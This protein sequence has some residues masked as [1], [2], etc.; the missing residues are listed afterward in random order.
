MKAK[1]LSPVMST[2]LSFPAHQSTVHT[3]PIQ[4]PASRSDGADAVPVFTCTGRALGDKW[5][6]AARRGGVHHGAALSAAASAGRRAYQ[7]T[8]A[9]PATAASRQSRCKGQ[10]P[11]WLDRHVRIFV[12]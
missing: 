2:R 12:M 6:R 8:A 10:R 3:A 11:D 4:R 7:E 9:A 1:E 5:V